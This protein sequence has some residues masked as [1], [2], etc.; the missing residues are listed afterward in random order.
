MSQREPTIN[1]MPTTTEL[2]WAPERAALY[3]LDISLVLAIRALKAAHPMLDEAG[4]APDHEPLLLI[5]E[6]LVATARSLHELISG[7]ELLVDR[8]TRLDS[9][10]AAAVSRPTAVDA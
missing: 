3:G 5:S 9:S 6:T 10:Y 4:E 2:Y 1:C 8:L 7:Y